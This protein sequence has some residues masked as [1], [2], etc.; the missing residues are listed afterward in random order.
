MQE[1]GT[2]RYRDNYTDSYR[3]TYMSRIESVKIRRTTS[4]ER[5]FC[6]HRYEQSFEENKTRIKIIATHVYYS[7][8]L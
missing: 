7:S 5:K 6:S 4:Y 3:P 2:S 1:L 8:F